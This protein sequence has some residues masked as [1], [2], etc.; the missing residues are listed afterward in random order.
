[1][2][3][4]RGEMGVGEMEKGERGGELKGDRD[5]WRRDDRD[6]GRE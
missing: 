6:M 2:G 3:V 4:G 1:M 5:R